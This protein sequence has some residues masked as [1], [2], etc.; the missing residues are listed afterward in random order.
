MNEI[1]TYNECFVI[2]EYFYMDCIFVAFSNI[3][4]IETFYGH[5][6]YSVVSDFF[7]D[8]LCL[9]IYISVLFVLKFEFMNLSS[10]IEFEC[11][12]LASESS[13]FLYNCR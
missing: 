12:G 11:V 13:M 8:F 2:S 5:Y 4:P 9:S 7:R 3:G 10:V 6:G 1:S